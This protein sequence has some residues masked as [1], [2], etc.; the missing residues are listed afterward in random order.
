MWDNRAVA[1]DESE[2]WFATTQIVPQECAT[3][4]S[5]LVAASPS[6]LVLFLWWS[7]WTIG[8]RLDKEFP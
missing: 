3:L 2:A 5:S 7:M 1:T 6:E 8:R 4:H